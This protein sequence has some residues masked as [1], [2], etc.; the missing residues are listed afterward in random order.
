MYFNIVMYYVFQCCNV[1][2]FKFVFRCC[3]IL[4]F[5]FVFISFVQTMADLPPLL[6]GQYDSTH[7]CQQWINP[8]GPLGGPSTFRCRGPSNRWILDARFVP[9]LSRS[10][11]LPFARMTSLLSYLNWTLVF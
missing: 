9:Y 3:N 4:C 1:L 5:K 7:R 2:C 6:D 10:G 11:L 8:E